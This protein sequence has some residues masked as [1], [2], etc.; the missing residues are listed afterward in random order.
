[1]NRVNVAVTRAVQGVKSAC[2]GGRASAPPLVTAHGPPRWHTWEHWFSYI[3]TLMPLAPSV[4]YLFSC[5]IFYYQKWQPEGFY[6]SLDHGSVTSL[7]FCIHA[8]AS[9]RSGLLVQ[10]PTSASVIDIVP[11]AELVSLYSRLYVLSQL[12]ARYQHSYV[13]FF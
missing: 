8:I 2:A 12:W 13:H 4:L 7:L 10:P 5:S 9:P 11:R 3:P 1:M 6:V